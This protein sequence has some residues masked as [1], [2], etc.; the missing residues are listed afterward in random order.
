M[1]RTCDHRLRDLVRSADD[2]GHAT[3]RGVPRSTARGWR[4]AIRAEVFTVDA[5]EMGILS[6][7][8]ELL[9]RSFFIHPTRSAIFMARLRV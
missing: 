8:Q 3:Q 9:A 5:V 2:I 7:Q 1:L 6:F 4:T